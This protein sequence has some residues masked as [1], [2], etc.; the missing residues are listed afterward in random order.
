[1]GEGERAA[2]LRA[3]AAEL[4][5]LDR[6]RFAGALPPDQVAALLATSQVLLAPSVVDRKGNRES[7]LI[8]VKEASAAEVVP[9]GTR[10]GGIPEII[11]DGRTGYLVPERDAS[12]L[13]DRLRQVVVDPLLR[14]RLGRAA[15][16][17]MLREYDVRAR[18]RAL[19]SLYDEAR[20]LHAGT[21]R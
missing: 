17:K 16:E 4:G 21:A 3:R 18:V 13:A 14:E 8:V 20:A 5:V 6:V 10:H 2:R 11:D 19:E 9:I 12:A 1:M 15:R 7:G